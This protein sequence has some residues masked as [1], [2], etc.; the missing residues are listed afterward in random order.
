M[1]HQQVTFTPTALAG[2]SADQTYFL[3]NTGPVPIRVAV[4]SSV[5]DRGEKDSYPVPSG[6]DLYPTPE[7]GE[8][9]Y[10][11]AE[12]QFSDVVYEEAD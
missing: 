2:V 3:R 1:A 10:V 12:G 4:A 9:V 5:P 6:G 11:W 8:S 7:S